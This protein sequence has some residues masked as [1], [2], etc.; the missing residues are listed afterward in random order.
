MDKETFEIV[1]RAFEIYCVC[2]YEI[3]PNEPTDCDTKEDYLEL[4][5][6]WLVDMTIKDRE[7]NDTYTHVLRNFN[8]IEVMETASR[9]FK[10]RI[11]RITRRN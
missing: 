4:F 10:L 5:K 1:V 9:V 2:Y 3:E 8:E 6:D 11:K 7:H